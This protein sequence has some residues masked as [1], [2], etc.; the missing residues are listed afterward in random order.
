M[1]LLIYTRSQ[2]PAPKVDNGVGASPEISWSHALIVCSFS[3]IAWYNVAELIVLIYT[4][5]KRHSGVYF[6]SMVVATAG[7]FVHVLGDF[8]KFFHLTSSHILYTCLGTFG[9]MAMVTGQSIVLWS[10]LHLVVHGD[11]TRW[12]LVVIIVNGVIWHGSTGVLTF[13]TN[14]SKDPTPYAGPY[15]IVEK[16]QVTVFFLQEAFLSGLYIWK[17]TQMLMSEGSLLDSQKHARGDRGRKILLHTIV[18]NV[19][20]ICMEIVIL[21]LEFAG[22]ESPCCLQQ[23]SY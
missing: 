9:W 5:F 3:T 14:L 17:T 21:V 16:I 10:R 20:I 18:T 12:V 2:V 8:L 4:F 23:R 7:I 6:Y 13:L 1:R 11:W 22:C 19:F 15:S